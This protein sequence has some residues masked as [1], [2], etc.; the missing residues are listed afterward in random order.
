MRRFELLLVYGLFGF[1][2]SLLTVQALY[3]TEIQ[4]WFDGHLD[5]GCGPGYTVVYHGI[6][7]E[8]TCKV[9]Q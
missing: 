3:F 9:K 6:H 2:V 7:Q 5:W 1:V 8:I 4:R